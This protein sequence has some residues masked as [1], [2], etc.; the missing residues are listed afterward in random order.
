[1]KRIVLILIACFLCLNLAACS[2]KSEEAAAVQYLDANFNNSYWFSENFWAFDDT[3]FYMRDGFYNMG[4]YRYANGDGV[5][6]FEESDFSNDISKDNYIGNIFIYDSYLYFK[7]GTDQGDWLY[8]Y[9]LEQGV[10]APVCEIPSLYRWVVTDDYFIYIEYSSSYKK[11]GAPLCIY[12]LIDGTTTQV[13]ANATEFGL[14]DGQLRYIVYS[15]DYELYQ[16]DY[17]ENRSTIL[18]TFPCEFEGDFSAYDIFNFTP[19]S[20]VMVN[21]RNDEKLVV[22]SIS[23]NS[24]EV[25]TLPNRIHH[26]VAYDQYAYAVVYGIPENAVTAAADERGIYRIKLSDGSYEIIERNADS[27]TEVHVVSDDCI[28]IVQGKMYLCL[29]REHVYQFDYTTKNKEKLF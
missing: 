1:M 15:D 23:S 16:Y 19:D 28:Y 13:C 25:Y 11:T 22:Y 27:D 6:L 8:R 21:W 5:K 2:E 26:M 4:V 29:Y 14:V 24:T 18:G 10:Y 20:I 17:A 3:L 9:D 7:L 12:N